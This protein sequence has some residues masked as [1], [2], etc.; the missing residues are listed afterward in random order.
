[1]IEFLI[2]LIVW[3]ISVV[4]SELIEIRCT[5]SGNR[6]AHWT[7]ASADGLRPCVRSSTSVHDLSQ[8]ARPPSKSVHEVDGPDKNPV[9]LRPL[10]I[11]NLG[12]PSESVHGVDGPDKNPV[13]HRPSLTQFRGP[14]SESVHEVDRPPK[15]SVHFRPSS[16]KYDGPPSKSVHH[17]DDIRRI[18]TSVVHL[19]K[20]TDGP[21]TDD[22]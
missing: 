2:H 21:S 19:D 17:M 4:Q 18:W 7:Q 12:P 5:I 15:I 11:K 1:M 6:F 8:Y 14:P 22:D 13:H 16:P 10:T 9:H 20:W 3:L